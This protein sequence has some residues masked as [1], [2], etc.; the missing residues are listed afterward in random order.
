MT[1]RKWYIEQ[2]TAPALMHRNATKF[3]DHTCQLFKDDKGEVQKLTYSE[4]Y[5]TVKELSCGLMSTGFKKGDRAAVMCNTAPQWMWSDY[6]ILCAGGITVC[7]YPTLSEK[8]LEFILEDSGT[9]AIF[10]EGP[11]ILEKVKNVCKPSNKKIKVKQII[12]MKD[13]YDDKDK[14]VTDFSRVRELGVAFHAKDR[15]AFE[16]RWR[17]VDFKDYM[18]IVYTSGT[19]GNPKGAVHTHF[20]WAAAV[21]RDCTVVNYASAEQGDLF[22]SFLPMSHTYE[23]ECGHGASM[24]AVVPNA[25]SSPKT[26]VE[27]LKLFKPTMFMSVPRIYE[28]VYMAMRD[29]AAKSPLKKKIFDAAI[30]T[31]IEVVE[32]R[33]DKDGFIDMTEGIDLTAGVNPWLKFK[34]KLFDK[35]I[36]SKVREAFGGRFRFAFSAAGSL[37]AD[38]CKTFLAMGIKITEGYGATETW[39]EVTVNRLNKILPGSIGKCSTT[40]IQLKVDEDGELLIKGDCLFSGYWNNPKATKDAFTED[41]YYKSGDIVEVLADNYIRIVDRKK[42]LMV[43]DTGKNVPSQRIESLFSLSRFI[44]MVVPIGS[45]RKYVSAIVVPNFDACI[46]YFEEK[47]IPFDKSAVEYDHNLASVPVCIKVGT[48]FVENEEFKKLIEQEVQAVNKELESYEQIKKYYVVDYK[49]TEV[50][51]ELTPTL[52]VKRRIVMDK[53]KKEIDGL[54]K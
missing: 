19:T 37:N 44:E 42:G 35:I 39:N 32:Q 40:A 29:Q 50:S 2:L 28:R 22:L 54:Y 9:T 4:V 13:N 18:T 36:F 20:S 43:L 12:V 27:D 33:A 51:G 53:F 1:D 23:R 38:L 48:D 34:F 6:S 3:G 52:K 7:I 41:G 5:R 46:E 15:M 17:S 26:L 45:E 31:G 10:V 16:D 25:Y 14:R 11:E 49:F 30:K 8:E 21:S 24:L 47:G